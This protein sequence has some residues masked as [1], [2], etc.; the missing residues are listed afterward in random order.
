MYHRIP[1]KWKWANAYTKDKVDIRW[2]HQSDVTRKMIQM[3]TFDLISPVK[4]ITKWSVVHCFFVFCFVFCITHVI[5]KQ[6]KW[7]I[8]GVWYS[9]HLSMPLHI[10][11]DKLATQLLTDMLLFWITQ[12]LSGLVCTIYVQKSCSAHHSRNEGL[13]CYCLYTLHSQSMLLHDLQQHYTCPNV[14]VTS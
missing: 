13:H 6:H 11:F 14:L 1:C 7:L 2:Y 10:M 12:C 9:C 8:T 3:V 5:R 4:H